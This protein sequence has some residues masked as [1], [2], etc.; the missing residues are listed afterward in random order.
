[1]KSAGIVASN[2]LIMV[3]MGGCVAPSSGS[4]TW[5]AN[6]HW[7]S[8]TSLGRAAKN[9]ITAPDVWL[10]IA[11]A[12]LLLAADVDD[13]W[14]QDL[15]DDQPIFG[16]GAEKTS[17]SLRDIASG[18]YVIS[19]LLAPSPSIEA[20]VRGLAVG[21]A[22]AA[23]DGLLSEGFKQW[24]S[25]QRP[26]DSNDN[27]MPSGHASKAAS[28]ITMARENIKHI[29]MSGWSRSTLN[30]ALHGVAVGTGLAR[31]EAR[32]HHLSDV[33]V[34]YAL[35]NFVARFMHEAFLENDENGAQI[36]F[37]QVEDGGALTLTLPLSR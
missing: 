1:M 36:S 32:R 18:A 19:A 30:W 12:G 21:A 20:K 9:A 23:V 26:D 15:A 29:Q 22:T 10:P 13:Q 16:S 6:A 2:I 7:P 37:A 11:T 27:S 34:G 35:G 33:F 5:G 8:Y 24:S 3:F 28:R 14:S 25:R 17:S 31:V 4:N